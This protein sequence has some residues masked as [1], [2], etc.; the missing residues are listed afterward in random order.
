MNKT[1]FCTLVLNLFSLTSLYAAQLTHEPYTP[2]NTILLF[3]IDETLLQRTITVSQFMREHAGLLL[4]SLP[5]APKIMKLLCKGATA[6]EYIRVCED[7]GYNDIADAIREIQQSTIIIP[8]MK[9]FIEARKKEGYELHIATNQ[10]KEG[11]E[12]YQKRHPEFFANFDY[13][14]LGTRADAKHKKLQKPDRAYYTDYLVQRPKTNKPYTYFFDDRR[15]NI[16]G[17]K[18]TGIDGAVFTTPEQAEKDFKK[19]FLSTPTTTSEAP[20]AAAIMP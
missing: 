9:E 15:K 5:I 2:K 17:A 18:E 4:R 1:L 3:D 20:C 10:Y 8:G 6:S 16:V 11:F 19:Y 7:A 13:V 14:Y 12:V